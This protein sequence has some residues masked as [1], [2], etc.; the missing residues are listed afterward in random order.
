MRVTIAVA[1]VGLFASIARKSIPLDTSETLSTAVASSHF[2]YILN[3]AL[4]S[5]EKQT[6]KDLTAHPL[7]SQL[8]SCDSLIAILAVLQEMVREF[9]QVRSHDKRLTKWLSPTVFSPAKVV[10]A[11]IGVFLLVGKDVSASQDVVEELF[12]WME[13]F[14][15]RLEAY[16]EV[17]PTAAM[18]DIITKIMVEVLTI[19][20]IATKE[21]KQGRGKRLL[22]KS[23]GRFDIED[24]LKQLDRLTQEEARMALAEALKI[25]HTIREVVT[26]G[27]ALRGLGLENVRPEPPPM[28]WAGP[29]FGPWLW[30]FL[31]GTKTQDMC[32]SWG[33]RYIAR[34]CA[35]VRGTC[36]VVYWFAIVRDMLL[37]KG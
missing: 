32:R 37:L 8:Q 3:A 33:M 11:G 2:Q 24:A 18:M 13:F 19:F 22:K 16:T 12:E 26:N 1:H 10:F 15:K 28:A 34:C 35:R 17:T 23:A 20:E 6:K 31:R 25:T 9:N 36:A 29:A 4:K 14:F 21:I 5:Y 7:A 30:E 27:P